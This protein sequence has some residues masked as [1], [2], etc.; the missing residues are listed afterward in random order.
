[1]AAEANLLILRLPFSH[2]ATVF[3]STPNAL[4]NCAWLIPSLL[5]TDFIW[6]GVICGFL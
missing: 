5:R 1:M 4:A 6:A 3:R 2:L